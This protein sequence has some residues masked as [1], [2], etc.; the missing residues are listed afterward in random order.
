MLDD[1]LRADRL[2]VEAVHLDPLPLLCTPLDAQCAGVYSEA[3]VR[4]TQR[5]FEGALVLLERFKG[6]SVLRRAHEA[7]PP[8]TKA[9]LDPRDSLRSVDDVADLIGGEDAND[10][11]DDD[12]GHT[13]VSGT[14]SVAGSTSTAAPGLHPTVVVV[15]INSPLPATPLQVHAHTPNQGAVEALSPSRHSETED[16]AA[17]AL[18]RRCTE[19]LQSP[20]GE[21]FDGVWEAADK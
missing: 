21:S 3:V 5:D 7:P 14:A 4:Y 2:V 1:R 8:A 18:A 13:T 9:P 19:A 11:D 6:L 15:P 20:P 10:D 16:V 17:T 12:G